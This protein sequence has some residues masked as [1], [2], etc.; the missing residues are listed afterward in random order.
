M[1]DCRTGCNLQRREA[2]SEQPG[3]VASSCRAGCRLGGE[4]SA[5]IWF[6]VIV[7]TVQVESQD[8]SD[9]NRRRKYLHSK[10]SVSTL[11]G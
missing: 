5:L 6:P 8:T 9:T 7:D 3:V 2:S 1:V 10:P 4:S 11:G